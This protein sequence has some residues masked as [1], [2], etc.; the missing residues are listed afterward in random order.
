MIL[1]LLFPDNHWNRFMKI[2]FDAKRLFNNFTG[3]GNYSR[4]L[5]KNLQ[6]YYPE[7]L[8]YLYTPGIRQDSL[9]SPFLNAAQYRTVCHTGLLKSL[10]RTTGI[11][12]DLKKDGIDL[13]HGLSH[14]I[15]L[16]IDQT[17][18]RS[19]VTIHDLIY[20]TYPDM[21]KAIDRAIYDYKFRYACKHADK[22]IAISESTKRDIIR[23]Y[24]IPEE[25]IKVIYQAIQPVFYHMQTEEAAT[26]IVQKYRLP[27][28]YLLYVGAINSR[29]NLSGIVKALALLPAD[30]KIPLVI[31]G[32]GHRYKEEV[33]RYARQARL[34][35]RLI[36][37]NN[38]HN[39][40][41]L[42]A[43][44]QKA[45]I[46]IYPSF[47]EG[48]GLPVTEALLSKVP[49][50]TSGC[51]SLPEAGGDAAYYIRP[52]DPEEIAEAIRKVLTDT[53]CRRKMIEKGY[54][55]AHRQFNAEK[56]TEQ[57]HTLYQETL[58]R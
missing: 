52:E 12:K 33:L 4:T 35:D 21:Y 54:A 22:I 56:L 29:K 53:E 20:L 3:L 42:Q 51:S 14:E 40:L 17:R 13:F 19:I 9:T 23:Y 16:D 49:V 39:P 34:S 48:F 37:L 55:F 46:F 26:D 27:Q 31:V 43:F 10:W 6:L 38:L 7:D 24:H 28:D 18:T 58:N 47:Y 41:E 45:R 2:G 15:P 57:I 8:Y 25:K 5:V 1:L 32:N 36:L 11:K 30:L 44:Y 50:I